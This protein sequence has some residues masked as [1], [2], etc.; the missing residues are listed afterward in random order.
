M[1]SRS[2]WWPGTVRST[3]S[4]VNASPLTPAISTDGD[5]GPVHR[6]AERHLEVAGERQRRWR[7]RLHQQ[8]ERDDS[9]PPAIGN[10]NSQGDAEA[11]RLR[12]GSPFV[13]HAWSACQGSC[14]AMR[15][16][17]LTHIPSI[18]MTGRPSA[19][20]SC[21]CT[22][23]RLRPACRSDGCGL[24]SGILRHAGAPY[25]LAGPAMAGDSARH[26]AAG[27]AAAVDAT[28]ASLRCE[29]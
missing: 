17:R 29:A 3:T 7:R 18:T 8:L 22:P 15:D 25:A 20:T 9:D 4:T 26:S 23:R 2:T 5:G 11:T 14:R 6:S 27:A 1:T 12:P 13:A 10:G 16:C 19:A 28:G 21:L 24:H